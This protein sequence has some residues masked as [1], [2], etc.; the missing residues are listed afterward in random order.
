MELREIWNSGLR[1]EHEDDERPKKKGCIG[2]ETK[3]R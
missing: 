2:K 1:I 3:L